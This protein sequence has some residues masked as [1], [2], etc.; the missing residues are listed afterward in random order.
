MPVLSNAKHELFAQE[1]AK[2]NSQG[3][4]YKT[5]GY[6][7]EG[8]AAES[9]GNRL[10]KN[11]EVQARIVELQGRGAKRAE[12]TIESLIQEAAEIQAAALDSGQHSAAV[13]ALTAKAKLSGLWVEKTENRNRN[14]D[15]N[16][17]SDD[18]LA[19]H[20]EGDSGRNSSQAPADTAKLN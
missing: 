18:E 8:H 17:L 7:A 14:I 6:N 16:G 12:V 20:I 11:V 3:E 9:A 4:A 1:I 10:M 19:A 5:A 2:G 15:A 13:A